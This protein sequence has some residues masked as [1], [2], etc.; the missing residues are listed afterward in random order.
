M[1]KGLR[2]ATIWSEDLNNL[3][4]FYRDVLGLKVGLQIEGFV[5]LGDLKTPAL[6]LGTHSEV[7]GH[8]A[9]PARHMVGLATDDVD[10]EC[11]RLKGAG[12]EFVEDPTDY[13]T[14][15]IATLKDPEGNL[16]QLLQPRP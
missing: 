1:I 12:V 15:R 8:N 9:D 6:A 11:K 5:V 14:L 3:L 10:A 2:G 13:G 16:L 4:P 7:H